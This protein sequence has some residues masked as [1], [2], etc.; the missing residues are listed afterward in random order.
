MRLENE[1]TLSPPIL[2]NQ[3]FSPN[4]AIGFLHLRPVLLS[5]LV[6]PSLPILMVTSCV[7]RPVFRFCA[8]KD[9]GTVG[10]I[11]NYINNFQGVKKM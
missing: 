3:T 6:F 8:G 7:R 1:L 9:P 11:L 10:K 4:C 2:R 5:S